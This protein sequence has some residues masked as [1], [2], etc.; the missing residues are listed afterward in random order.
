MRA[1]IL[2]V[3]IAISVVTVAWWLSG[4][5]GDFSLTLGDWTI[6]MATPIAV[7]L[8]AA[9]FLVLYAI[10]RLLAFL[11]SVPGRNR[12]WRERQ[13]R[14]QGDA[15]VN[16][17]LIALA[18]NDA[19]AARREAERARRSLGDTPLTLLLAA[20]SAL[21]AGRE[22]EAQ[23]IFQFLAKSRDGKLL[24]L[25]GL[26]RQAMARHD[27]TAATQIAGQAE[28]AHPGASWLRVERRYLALRTGHWRD[29]LR[30]A[31][32]KERAAIAVAAAEQEADPNRALKLARQAFDADPGLP[33]AALAYAGRLRAAGRDRPAQEVLRR[34]W[35]A[36][37]QP[38][39]AEAYVAKAP[40][41]LARFREMGALVR[42]NEGHVESVIALGRAAL[43]AGLTG[44]ARRHVD[45]AVTRGVNERRLWTLLAD[46]AEMDGKPDEAQEALRRMQEASPDPV[47]RC[48]NCG[49]LHSIWHPTCNACEAVGT[50]TWTTQGGDTGA[51]VARLGQPAAIEG[52]TA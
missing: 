31:G 28:A 38:E 49:A 43:E 27:W 44:E 33:A 17:T 47:W 7:V 14:R 10:I 34:A 2:F 22:S 30:L 16:R 15:A 46:I 41:K 24:G 36:H 29:A 35:S 45:A 26:M 25:R 18:A 4:I 52:L 12:R 1:A 21:Q 40:D 48:T 32:S 50:I 42:G 5:P 51:A 23:T 37:P 39:L 13:R 9:L 3:L 20:Q 19:G 6:Q 11:V 8:A